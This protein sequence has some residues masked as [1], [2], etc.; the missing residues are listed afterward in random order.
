M[1]WLPSRN[2]IYHLVMKK[3]YVCNQAVGEYRGYGKEFP[4][5]L[6]KQC[7]KNCLKYADKLHKR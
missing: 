5:P 2:G 3:K 7:C 4:L 6:A 1:K